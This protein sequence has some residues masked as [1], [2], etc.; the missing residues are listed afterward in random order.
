MLNVDVFSKMKDGVYI[1]NFVCGIF[2]DLE[3][4]IKVLDSGKVV[5]VVFD[6]YEYE[7]KIFNKDF[8]G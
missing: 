8:E 5:G 1:L 2:I 4:L 3:D 7:I 6:M